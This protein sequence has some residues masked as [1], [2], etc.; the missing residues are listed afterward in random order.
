VE[1]VDR[2]LFELQHKR[3]RPQDVPARR[4]AV[5]AATLGY[6]WD[7]GG[8][9]CASKVSRNSSDRKGHD[10]GRDYLVVAVGGDVTVYRYSDRLDNAYGSSPTSFHVFLR[11]S[12]PRHS[13][14]ADADMHDMHDM[15]MDHS[16]HDGH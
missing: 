14:M 8:W 6:V 9:P 3:Q 7:V 12:G 5:D 4:T 10:S 2:D 11:L 1:R 13:A 15:P 16:G